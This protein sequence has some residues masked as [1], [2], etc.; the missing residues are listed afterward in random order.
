MPYN[1]PT[2]T[3]IRDRI[4]TDIEGSLDKKT[5]ILRKNIFRIFASAF[6]AAVH[7]LYGFIEWITKQIFPDTAEDEYLERWCKIW[8]VLRKQ[9]T[10][11]T[12]TI[13][14]TGINGS[15]LYDGTIF[16]NSSDIEYK[17]VGDVAIS[18]TSATV[19]VK[20]SKSGV[21]GNMLAGDFVDLVSPVVGIDSRAT[22]IE[23]SGGND[24]ESND[25]LRS[26]L[27]QRIQTLIRGGNEEDY[28]TWTLEVAGVTRAWAFE[29]WTGIGKVGIMFV[30]DNATPIIPDTT[31]INTV[32]AYL[33]TKRPLCSQ[34]IVFPPS[35]VTLNL[36]IYL[37]PAD[38]LPLKEAIINAIKEYLF[39]NNRPGGT[40]YLS[41]IAEVIASVD[42]E[43]DSK[44]IAPTANITLESNQIVELGTVTWQG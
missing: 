27:L 29:N 39:E 26:R 1:R 9:P 8:N 35:I 42:G 44:I 36:T 7:G 32:K 43:I 16:K 3:T 4:I 15:I 24:L 38:S 23:I 22:V 11:A 30:N 37:S 20:S 40:I 12:G 2:L 31:F 19:T 21:I 6:A 34:L 5:P 13:T 18:G 17:S 14:I 28:V 41:Q 33:E 25:D 10:F